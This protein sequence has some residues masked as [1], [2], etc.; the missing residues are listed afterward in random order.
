MAVDVAE[1]SDA[2]ALEASR[3]LLPANE[4][5]PSNSLLLGIRGARFEPGEPFRLS[6]VDVLDQRS[7][8]PLAD[9]DIADKLTSRPPSLGLP[10]LSMDEHANLLIAR[11]GQPQLVCHD[12]ST[13]YGLSDGQRRIVEASKRS[14]ESPVDPWSLSCHPSRVTHARSQNMP[15]CEEMETVMRQMHTK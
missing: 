5:L 2:H 3:S 9:V 15:K 7:H 10:P 13:A 1:H 6:L 14:N 12:T 11:P 8:R 4:L